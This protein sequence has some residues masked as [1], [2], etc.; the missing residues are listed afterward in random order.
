[1]AKCTVV[2]WSVA[3]IFLIGCVDPIEPQF[4]FREGIFFIDGFISDA[5]G[6][7][8]VTVSESKLEGSK[9]INE[10]ISGARVEVRNTASLNTI[11]FEEEDGIYVAPLNFLAEIGQRYELYIRLPSGEEY[12]SQPEEVIPSVEISEIDLRYEPRLEFNEA[13]DTFNPGHQVL[14]SFED[15]PMEENY[16]YWRFRSFENLPFCEV[17]TEAI[18][19]DNS[20][21]SNPPATSQLRKDYYM[22]ACVPNCWQIR[23]NETVEVFADE[24]IDGRLVDELPVA[25][26]FL[27][28]KENILVELQQFSL[29][30]S[31]YEYYRI[32]RDIVDNSG[33]FNSPPPAALIGNI[34]SIDD[35][36]EVV[37]GRFTAASAQLRSIF[38]NRT[39]LQESQIEQRRPAQFEE[40]GEVPPFPVTTAPCNETFTRTAIRPPAWPN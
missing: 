29:N 21:Q 15:P 3:A 40:E 12:R 6:S 13:E 27:Y 36:D 16:Y 11:T 18:F 30:R 14:V 7:S 5:T 20:C 4:D 31:A 10:F 1:M 9:Y 8:F 19:R 26:V 35:E 24:F 17:C 38:I 28:T 25:D 2:W 39:D 33:G 22:Y 37:L 23:Y 34:I 32:L